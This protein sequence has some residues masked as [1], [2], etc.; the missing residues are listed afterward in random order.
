MSG[1]LRLESLTKGN[2]LKQGDKTPLRYRLFDADGEKLNVAGKSAKVR[3]VYPDFLTIGYEKEGL[4]VAQDD[5]VTFTID[6]VIPSRIYHVEIIVDDKFIFPSRADES[7]FTV[8]KSSL[9][10]ETNIIEIIG[11]DALVK[12][13][14]DLINKDPNLIID[15][16]KLVNDIISNSGIGDINAYYKAFNDLKPKAELS[17]TRSSEAL[18]KSQNALNISNGIDAKATTALSLSES[19]DTLSKSVQ[20]QFNQ[21][22]IDGDSSVEAAQARVTADGV[23]KATLKERLDDE[24]NEVTAQLAHTANKIPTTANGSDVIRLMN[25]YGNFQNIHPKV[26]YFPNGWNG[27]KY[28]MAY[29][30]YPGGN[31]TQENPCLAASNNGLDWGVPTGGTNQV[32][33]DWNGISNDYNNDTHLVYNSSTNK[34]EIWYRT[35]LGSQSKIQ[36]KRI[37]T[38]DG[39]TFESVEILR[40]GTLNSGDYISPAVIFEDNEYKM[41]SVSLINSRWRI[42]YSE[43][44]DGYT[45]TNE[46]QVN[47]E[48]IDNSWWL[49]HIDFISS[50]LGYEMVIQGFRT[51][52]SSNTSDLYYSVSTDLLNWSQPKLIL[53]KSTE[54][55]AFDNAGIYRS[56]ILKI[57]GVYNIYY[58][59]LNK[60]GV[61]S[62]SLATGTNIFALKGLQNTDYVLNPVYLQFENVNVMPNNQINRIG[63]VRFV[64]SANEIQQYTG[65]RWIPIKDNGMGIILMHKSANQSV[66][67][68]TDTPVTFDRKIENAEDYFVND[69]FT[70]PYDGKYRIAVSIQF[71]GLEAGDNVEVMIKIGSAVHYLSR[72]SVNGTLYMLSQS[73]IFVMAKGVTAQVLV[74]T[75]RASTISRYNTITTLQIEKV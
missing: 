55:R 5:T 29:T 39:I 61:R 3:L 21:V 22:V 57:D 44:L 23:T 68:N 4:T 56:S 26:L 47:V 58:S 63:L 20:E 41:L 1:I 24:H 59:A 69:K 53:K 16:D 30:P 66:A 37:L 50:D 6:K 52:Q 40:E 45:W 51:G 12:K 62:L 13:A 10:T 7:K 46:Q 9:G 31:T 73:R 75:S 19:A 36:L 33:E 35:A 67:A 32:L 34:L 43:S 8:D 65:S 71:S 42:S 2:T 74:K 54:L 48:G 60:S 38:S 18:T 25:P 28:W 64:E 14:V 49:W 15:E 72:E 17:I 11:V 27:Y 70:A